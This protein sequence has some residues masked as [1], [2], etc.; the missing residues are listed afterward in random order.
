MGD[1]DLELGAGTGA[2]ISN[3]GLGLGTG[4]GISKWGLVLGIWIQ[5]IRRRVKE[6]EVEYTV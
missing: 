4:A 6:L 5:G 2:E 1:G 3:W